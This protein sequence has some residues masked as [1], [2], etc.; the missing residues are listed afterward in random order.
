MRLHGDVAT[1][2]FRRLVDVNFI[3]AMGP[4]GGGRNP[5]TPRLM[6]HFNYLAFTELEDESKKKIFSTILDWW[7][8]KAPSLKEHC[9]TMVDACI[10]VYNTITT[11]LLPTPAKSHYTFNLRD[12]S[13]V[14]QGLLMADSAKMTV[15]MLSLF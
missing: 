11:Q 10:D 7:L 8:E 15:R 6:R 13:K 3:C 14:F 1:G 2:D 9:S 4:P 5:V 12:L